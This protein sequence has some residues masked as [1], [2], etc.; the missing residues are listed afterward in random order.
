MRNKFFE[1]F[2]DIHKGKR[3]FIIAN[4]PSLADTNL[5][6]I[7]DEISIAMNRVSLI[8][9][10][11]EWRPT[12]YLFSSTNV[13][14]PEWGDAWTTSVRQSIKTKGVT[15]FISSK[16]RKRI[17]PKNKYD[18]VHWINSVSENKP[19]PTGEIKE[20]CFS[21]N[22]VDRIDK[23]GTSINLA[24][25]LAYH[26]G[27]SELVL[28]GADLGWTKDTG[29]KSDPNHFDNSYRANIPNPDKANLQM[30]NVHALALKNFK[31]K[32]SSIKL[33]NA[34]VKTV[35]DIYPIID[36]EEYVLNSK[37]VLRD[38]DQEEAKVFWSVKPQY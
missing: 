36:F 32:D 8:Y 29:S 19:S 13:N 17:D 7:K 15:S 38:K 2:K 37:V 1:K 31:R 10:R 33:Y 14:N 3:G 27:F 35:L 20:S 26:M 6:L 34:S 21:T 9:D 11:C 5:D 23:S 12:Y 25:Q 22:I 18:N 24:L 28:V 4:G 30:R 16:F